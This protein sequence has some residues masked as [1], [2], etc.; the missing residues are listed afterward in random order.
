MV[1]ARRT[2]ASSEPEIRAQF[3][4][5]P[6]IK[7]SLPR[8]QGRGRACPAQQLAQRLRFRVWGSRVSEPTYEGLVQR[9]DA[10]VHPRVPVLVPRTRAQYA[11]CCPTLTRV[12]QH[13]LLWSYA[14]G[15]RPYGL[16]PAVAAP[17]ARTAAKSNSIRCICTAG[18]R[19]AC[20]GRGARAA[21]K[22]NT[23]RWDLYRRTAQCI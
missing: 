7:D 10:P 6:E 13:H 14:H 20:D 22:S 17:A 18:R 11:W 15:V 16:G 4:L 5:H 8:N 23:L 21:A 3:G 1:S 2:H 19:K 12:L 9:D